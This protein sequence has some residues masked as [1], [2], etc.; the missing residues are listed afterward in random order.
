MKHR[1]AYRQ[2][3]LVCVALA[4]TALLSGAPASAAPETQTRIVAAT[5]A[6]RGSVVLKASLNP[7]WRSMYARHSASGGWGALEGKLADVRA[8]PRDKLLEQVNKLVNR[9]RQVSDRRNWRSGDYWAAP[10][11]LFQRGGDC[12][13]FAIAKYLLLREFGVPSSHMQ[14]LIT[15]D[16]AVLVVQDQDGLVVLDSLRGRPYQLSRGQAARAVFAL[17]EQSWWVNTRGSRLAAR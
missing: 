4:G 7:K 6:W 14:I 11:E 2:A 13:D 9:A 17:N 1:P 10:S 8:A 15:R 16:H 3:L 12:E 5:A